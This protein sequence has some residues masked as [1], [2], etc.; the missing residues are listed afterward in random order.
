M[1]SSRSSGLEVA[2]V[3]SLTNDLRLLGVE[4]GD[5]VFVQSSFRRLGPLENGAQ[6]VVDA[7]AAAVGWEGLILM[8]SFHLIEPSRRAEEWNCAS[9]EA[10]TGWLT[11]FFRRL[12][13][14][15]R[16]DHYSH[17]VAARGAAAAE[18]VGGMGDDTGMKSPWDR[19]P[20]RKTFGDQSPFFRCYKNG[21]KALMLGTGYDTQTFLHLLEVMDW[22]RRLERDPQADYRWIDRMAAGAVWESFGE[23]RSGFVG[24]ALSRLFSI[25]ALID[26]LL[27]FVASDSGLFK[28]WPK[29][30]TQ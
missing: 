5:R 7:I 8:P 30:S 20:W 10:T 13:G 24:Q 3:A 26:T 9:S 25:P 19:S 11:E 18:W 27:R 6:T 28:T 17:S 16:S 29:N 12:P 15:F 1:N 2:T 14:T 21:A 4:T 22:N 23:V